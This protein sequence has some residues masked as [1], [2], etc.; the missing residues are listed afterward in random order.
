MTP[1]GRAPSLIPDTMAQAEL[2]S[3]LAAAAA[4]PW[5]EA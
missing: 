1:G 4:R 5:R 3:W 2:R